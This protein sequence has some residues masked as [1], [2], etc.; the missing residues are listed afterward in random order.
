MPKG[1]DGHMAWKTKKKVMKSIGIRPDQ[2]K[3]LE[4]LSEKEDMSEAAIIRKALDQYL[5]K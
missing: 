4:S 1:W 2:Q 5:N 3:K